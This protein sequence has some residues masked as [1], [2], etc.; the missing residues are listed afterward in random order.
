[1]ESKTLQSSIATPPDSQSGQN[2]ILSA[3]QRHKKTEINF[4][5]KGW[6]KHYNWLRRKNWKA[7]RQQAG[8]STTNIWVHQC[9]ILMSPHLKFLYISKKLT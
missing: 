5:M 2:S 1:M 4:A 7:F 3:F 6:R 9:K 8:K